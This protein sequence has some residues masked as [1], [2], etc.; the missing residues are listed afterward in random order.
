VIWLLVGLSFAFV[1][2]LS[3]NQSSQLTVILVAFFLLGTLL[4]FAFGSERLFIYLG[5]Y[6]V[7][8]GSLAFVLK[9]LPT[10]KWLDL[11]RWRL[12][13]EMG[14][15]QEQIEGLSGSGYLPGYEFIDQ[16]GSGGMANVY[17]ARRD[18][19]GQIV[20][21]KI[22]T[23]QYATDEDYLR[24]FHR[25]A[26]VVRKLEHSNIIKTFDHGV[27]GVKHFMEMEFI[28][29]RGLDTYIQARELSVDIGVGIV[30]L[31]VGGLQ[32]IH[33][34]G[35]IHR[36]I[37][38]SNI[39]IRHDGLR[40]GLPSIKPDSVK[41]MDFG[42]A[43]GKDLHPVRFDDARVGTPIYMS[44]E[45]VRGLEIDH[46]SDIYSL[47]LVFYE[48]LTNQAAFEGSSE[49]TVYQQAFQV[50]LSPRQLNCPISRILEHLVMRMIAKDPD[51]RPSL[52]DVYE[53]LLRNDLKD[54]LI[55]DL[56]NRLVL[57]V[58]THQ[59]VLR[60]LDFQ[61]V[62]YT[63][64]GDI[65]VVPGSFPTTP[66]SV[67]V[68]THGNYFLAVPGDR[69]GSDDLQLIRKLAP[70][71]TPLEDFGAYGMNSGELIHPVTAAVASD[72]SVLVLDSETHFVKR[73]SNEGKYLSS[74]G[75][76]GGGSGLFNDPRDLCVGPDGAIYVLDYGNRQI[77]EFSGEG[78]YET[79]WAFFV[80]PEQSA[81][82]LLDGLTVDKTGNLYV[83]DVMER[84]VRLITPE[85]KVARSYAIGV[86]KGEPKN[87]LLDLGVD[88]DGF[89]YVVRRG[90]HVIRKLDCNGALVDTLET[91]SPVMQMVV[92]V[93]FA[94][95][96]S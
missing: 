43:G 67:S 44:P 26:E 79:R 47:G 76:R 70:D 11:S 35:V 94:K 12:K 2:V 73:F 92:D 37:K 57:T 39:M 41:L 38:P 30:Q 1:L 82:R 58:S 87:A 13:R 24:R 31:L 23:N 71:G 4:I 17:R 52:K 59:G 80:N 29:G 46:R 33:D 53:T 60:I 84:R 10:S 72:D 32:H 55:T 91:Y 19:D 6:A 25:E 49:A 16:V 74:F 66:M 18:S 15:F 68:D 86:I 90:G 61:G 62:L 28:E 40:E 75:G 85:G 93:P 21:L 45:Q 7:A 83:S 34:A 22:P 77:Q 95:G 65:G 54:T 81:R 63:T 42:I 69:F 9:L 64:L 78:N 56:E 8:L 89:L 5:W 20:A 51:D 50:P 27:V 88:A 3:R 36:D 14:A 96:S 48:M